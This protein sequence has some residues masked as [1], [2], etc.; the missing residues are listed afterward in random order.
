M[1][2]PISLLAA[3]LAEAALRLGADDSDVA[4]ERPADETRGDYA[5][6]LALR[7][8]KPLRRAAA[9]DRRGAAR[10]G[11]GERRGS[12]SAEVAGPGFLNLRA[13][14]AWYARGAARRARRR[15]SAAA[16]A[17]QPLQRST[18]SSS[19]PTPPGPLP[20][21][22]PQR[23][24]RRLPRP[25]ARVR[26]ARRRARVLLQ[27]RRARRWTTSAASLRGPGARRAG[28]RGRLPGRVPDRASPSA[29]ASARDAPARRVRAARASEAM[30]AR[31]QGDAHALPRHDGRLDER[32]RVPRRA[33]TSRRRSQR[34]RSA[35]PPARA[36]TARPGCVTEPFGDDKDRV[37]L[38]SDGSP[39][40]FAADL[41]YLIDKLDRGFDK[42]LYV[43]GADHHGYVGRLRAAAAA[44]G[45][46]PDRVEVPIYQMVHLTEGGETQAH[47]EAPRRR[48]AARRAD[49][50]DRHRR[51]ALVP[52]LALARP[53]D[54]AR[55]R[56]GARAERQEPGL[57]R[58]VR[59]CPDRRDR[60]R[61]RRARG[62]GGARCDAASRAVRG[63]AGAR[64][65][66]VP[67]RRGRGCR[68]AVAAPDRGV[69]VRPRRGV[70]RLLPR[71]PR[72]RRRR[73]RAH[74]EQA[75]ALRA[76]RGVLASSL[77]LLGVDAP[78]EM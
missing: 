58:A 46:D 71:L 53:D 20:V 10:G 35:R 54:R 37:V 52:D 5:T 40:Y 19:P 21:G 12:A 8:A 33:A 16:R 73:S 62:R 44:L 27:R 24:L 68:P 30:F 36:A 22:R 42:A 9:R 39:T 34:A 51:G 18:S 48:G 6:S 63:R 75:R 11:A 23:G 59:A 60:A 2:D 66:R 76:A 41:A 57:L 3:P 14:P 13:S 69:L 50:S 47:V 74:E 25:A 61:R 77:D 31:D 67:P 17:E 49:G 72:A 38:R 32:G 45:F 78:E 65:R 28:A 64:D 43:L 26:R 7:L 56:A 4:L 29:R 70:P 55:H 15:G 1:S